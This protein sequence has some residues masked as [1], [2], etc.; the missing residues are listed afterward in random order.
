MKHLSGKRDWRRGAERS[1]NPRGLMELFYG[2]DLIMNISS[3]LLA[4]YTGGGAPTRLYTVKSA[5][6]SSVT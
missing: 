6:I 1:A 5:A 4:P 3:P 2:H